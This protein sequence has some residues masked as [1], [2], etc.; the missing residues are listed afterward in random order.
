MFFGFMGLYIPFYYVQNYAIEENI[1]SVDTAFYFL[2][3]LNAASIFGRIIPNYIADKTGPLNV[4]IPATFASCI[5]T[6]GWI[7]IKDVGGLVVFC[8]LYGFF[9]GSFV[10]IPPTVIVTISPHLGVVGT[11]LG[12]CFAV[13]GLGVLVGTPVAGQLLK[14][15][16]YVASIAFGGG[17]L[18]I[19][20]ALLIASR[21][22][23][24]GYKLKAIA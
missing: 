3:I 11:R 14:D 4:V 7:G 9:S 6:F 23:K 15:A 12:M 5:L 13:S 18:T 20:G 17:V 2:S 10:S 19:S 1:T 16:G 21:I 24:V 22:A 8:I